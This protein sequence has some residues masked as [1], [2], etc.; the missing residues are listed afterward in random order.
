[1]NASFPARRMRRLRAKDALRDLVAEQH[2]TTNDL[3]YPVFVLPGTG[4]R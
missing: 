3:I 4:Q 2:L 1:M